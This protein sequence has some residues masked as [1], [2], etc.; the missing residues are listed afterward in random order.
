MLYVRT[1]VWHTTAAAA[2]LPGAHG[3]G[4]FFR[5]LTFCSYTLQ[6]IQLVFCCLAHLTRVRA[7][8]GG[9]VVVA[10][11]QGRGGEACSRPT[12]FVPWALQSPSLLL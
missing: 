3:F 7:C 8:G 6:L 10:S 4:W 2:V 12:S 9:R 11:T 1:W 5:Y